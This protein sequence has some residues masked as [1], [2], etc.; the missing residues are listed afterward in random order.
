MDYW[1]MWGLAGSALVG[2]GLWMIWNTLMRPRSAPHAEYVE[3]EKYQRQYER[4]RILLPWGVYLTRSAL[5]GAL[6]AIACYLGVMNAVVL[7]EMFIFGFIYVYCA[8]EDRR[9][10]FTMDYSRDLAQSI[11]Y[12]MNAFQGK[13]SIDNSVRVAAQYSTG[14]VGED[15]NAIMAAREA[16]LRRAQALAPIA[17]KRNSLY[18]DGFFETLR[19][20]DRMKGVDV[21]NVLDG[22][23]KV[24]LDGIKAFKKHLIAVEN[25]RKEVRWAIF[26]PWLIAGA[27][28]WL[29]TL[30]SGPSVPLSEVAAF[31]TS[32]IGT[33]FLGAASVISCVG[34]WQMTRTMRSGIVLGRI[35]VRKRGQD[36]APTGGQ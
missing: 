18:L 7:P 12:M 32:F 26:G 24:M 10:H 28:R 34:Y 14:A 2:P 15:L 5:Y 21:M 30:V 13:E 36:A 9:D 22:Q 23:S 27:A 8:E 25:T 20:A 6:F 31:Y 1:L 17:E 19:V 33:L 3:V 16:N 4:A 11:S 29:P 35:P